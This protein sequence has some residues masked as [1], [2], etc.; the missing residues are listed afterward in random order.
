MTALETIG[1]IGTDAVK[2]LRLQKLRSGYPFMI[3]SNDLESRKFY[4]EFPDGTIQLAC[5]EKDAKEFVMIQ[6]LSTAEAQALRA[7]YGFSQL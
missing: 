7:K 4:L 1:K 3:N 6:K 5:L 2:E